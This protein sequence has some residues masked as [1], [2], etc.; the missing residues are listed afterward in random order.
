MP[1]ATEINPYRQA[2]LITV[3]CDWAIP[4]LKH[5]KLN[6]KYREGLYDFARDRVNEER[7]VE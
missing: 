1:G 4:F 5:A 7:E 6:L 3:P 2:I